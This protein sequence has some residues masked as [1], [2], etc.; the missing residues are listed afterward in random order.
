MRDARLDV[1]KI[2]GLV[3]QDLLAPRTKFVAHLSLENVKDQFEADVNM[4][5]GDAA[6]RNRR[7]VGRELGRPDI[8]RG[9]SLLVVNA[10][11]VAPRAAATNCQDAAVILDGAQLNAVLV[12][13]HLPLPLYSPA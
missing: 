9:H 3:F 1:N 11:P 8:L 4:G 12:V 5:V 7:D 2:A 13:L 10:V 6:R